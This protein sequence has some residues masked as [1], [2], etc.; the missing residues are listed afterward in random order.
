MSVTVTDASVFAPPPG[1]Y[2]GRTM[3]TPEP[4]G[5]VVAGTA[6]PLLT[7]HA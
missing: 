6:L 2:S 1:D 7:A 3:V 4:D 5:A